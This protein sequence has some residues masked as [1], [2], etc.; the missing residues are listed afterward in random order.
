MVLCGGLCG[1]VGFFEAQLATLELNAFE[2]IEVLCF[3]AVTE[4]RSESK[5]IKLLESI[6]QSNPTV[7]CERDHR[8]CA[9][10]HHA[11]RRRSVEFVKILV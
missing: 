5:M 7:M 11:A 6:V 4:T 8:G 1:K 10:L 9:L 2:S 3:P